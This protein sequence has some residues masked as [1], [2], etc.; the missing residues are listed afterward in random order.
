MCRLSVR[1]LNMHCEE[2]AWCKAEDNGPGQRVELVNVKTSWKPMNL[3]GYWVRVDNP[4]AVRL[5][6]S[7]SNLTPI[8]GETKHIQYEVDAAH[9]LGAACMNP[10]ISSLPYIK[11]SYCS[12]NRHPAVSLVNK[13]RQNRQFVI[14]VSV[15][16]R[17]VWAK[18]KTTLPTYE[19]LW[20]W[21]WMWV[22]R[23]RGQT[24]CPSFIAL[25]ATCS[26]VL[27]THN[28]A[29]SARPALKKKQE[30]DKHNFFFQLSFYTLVQS[31][32][33]WRKSVLG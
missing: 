26:F 8:D 12:L 3:I 29:R 9:I 1:E 23:L 6:T 22:C 2:I 21:V 11:D 32:H 16:L 4:D 28:E 24:T 17:D 15:W 18:W 30:Q 33:Q 14:L 19:K 10:P 25:S 20:V 27:L 31:T 7:L 13:V 5:S